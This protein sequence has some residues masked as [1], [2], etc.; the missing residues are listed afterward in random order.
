M[1]ERDLTLC[2]NVSCSQ[3]HSELSAGVQKGSGEGERR[4]RCFLE[5][6]TELD[7]EISLH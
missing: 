3:V 2:S 1:D 6:I 4:T 7:F 5:E